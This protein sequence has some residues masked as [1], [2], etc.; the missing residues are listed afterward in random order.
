MRG[1]VLVGLLFAASVLEA[2]ETP[3]PATPRAQ[4]PNVLVILVDDLGW[5]ELGALGRE[6]LETPSIDGLYDE[7][8]RFDSYYTTS[9]AC[10]PARA[11]L[12]SGRYPDRVGVQGGIRT[13]RKQ[14]WGDLA[15]DAVLLPA[16]LREAGYQTAM[17]G[18][19]HL[20]L[21]EPDLP[22]ARGFESF[23][24]F[25]GDMMDDYYTH[26]RQGRNFMRDDGEEVEAKGHATELFT[27]WACEFLRDRDEE[28]PFFLYL[29]YNAP[30]VPIQ[31]PADRLA[32]YRER[33][34]DVA[35]QRAA[36]CAMVEH[37]DESIGRVLA[38]LEAE[39]LA[40]DTLVL[41]A[42][43]N[44][45]DVRAGGRNGGLRGGKATLYEGGVRVPAAVRWPGR[46]Q[47]GGR[48]DRPVASIDVLPTLLELAGAEPDAASDGVSWVPLLDAQLA[49][50]TERATEEASEPRSLFFVY[51][52]AH[53]DG[54]KAIRAVRRGDWKLVQVHPARPLE[55]YDLAR[56]PAEANDLA[57]Q[58]PKRLAELR[59][60]I[61][62]H[63]RASRDV[64]WRARR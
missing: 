5:G 47:A 48:V 35:P 15:D 50:G 14:S 40:R 6:D 49:A 61:E 8:T 12:L 46:A 17:V 13:K 38:T 7:G 18:K 21:R 19:W 22:N 23:R 39:G 20:G 24:G 54:G 56:D 36:L 10:S 60:A 3:A 52:A 37:L 64:P 25:L 29:A 58:E 57:R 28:R 16:R 33:H 63:A 1:V 43:D 32:A 31:P 2:Q 11:S 51:R 62:E 30:H 42:S 53:L 45:A 9:C 34:P 26:E 41:F 59:A 44:G 27:D 4:R 55:L